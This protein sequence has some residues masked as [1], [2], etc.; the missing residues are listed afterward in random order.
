MS[1]SELWRPNLGLATINPLLT[2]P[3]LLLQ[4]VLNH[5]FTSVTEDVVTVKIDVATLSSKLVFEDPAPVGTRAAHTCEL[6]PIARRVVALMRTRVRAPSY[7]HMSPNTSCHLMPSH[8]TLT[9]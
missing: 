7:H 2:S 4:N 6:P 5:Y 8:I 1:T 3:P 9:S